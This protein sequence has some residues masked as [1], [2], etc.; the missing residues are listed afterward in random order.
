M[1]WGCGYG[2]LAR[3]YSG[4]GSGDVALQ[5]RYTS[6]GIAPNAF[7]ST[8]G[9][10]Y[11]K[12]GR[13][14]GVPVVPSGMSGSSG[15]FTVDASDIYSASATITEGSVTDT[16]SSTENPTVTEAEGVF[17]VRGD[18]NAQ[19]L[20]AHAA[21][22][23]HRR[24][25]MGIRGLVTNTDLDDIAI[26]DGTDTGTTKYNDPLQGLAVGSY[27]WFQA[28]V[29]AHSGGR[30]TAQRALTFTLM[31]KMFDNVEEAAGK[32][33]GPNLILTTRAIRREYLEL[34]QADRRYVNTMELDG[35]WTAID[36]NGVPLTV[37]NDAIDGEMYF[38]TTKEL[39]IY[40]MSDYNWMQKDGA[41]LSRITGYD[42]YEAVLYRYAE[43]GVTRRNTQGVLCDIDYEL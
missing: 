33:Y 10:K 9:A 35:G 36:Y 19:S 11:F 8:F 24:E 30:Y 2:I 43:L 18:A 42:A 37:D 23:G 15:T 20:G 1:M 16:L 38:L 4:D 6:N 21:S 40:R 39:N 29:D 31:Q 34:C 27:D 26:L 32:D 3:W 28:I 17:Y 7:G 25:M 14:S 13:I 41:V 22:G 5:K 12:E